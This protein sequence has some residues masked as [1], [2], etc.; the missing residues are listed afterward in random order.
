MIDHSGVYAVVIHDGQ[1]LLVRKARG[2]YAGQLD[3]PGGRAELGE[4]RAATL[5]RELREEI[6]ASAVEMRDWRCVRF[7]VGRD[8]QGRVIAFRHTAEFCRVA[9][10]GIP[11][12]DIRREDANG[13][14]W[15]SVAA[16]RSRSDLS[17]LVIEVFQDL[18]L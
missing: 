4:S 2:P 13:A 12:L 1:V 8:S 5:Q 18:D 14:L 16:W 10:S 6:G 15:I 9:L 3:L 11:D 17:P 7:D